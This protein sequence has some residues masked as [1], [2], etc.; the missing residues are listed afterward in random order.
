MSDINSAIATMGGGSRLRK[1]IFFDM[2][3]CIVQENPQLRRVLKDKLED[4]LDDIFIEWPALHS[5][6]N[7][8]INSMFEIEDYICRRTVADFDVFDEIESVT[9]KYTFKTIFMKIHREGTVLSVYEAASKECNNVRGRNMADHVVLISRCKREGHIENETWDVCVNMD[10]GLYKGTVLPDI[11]LRLYTPLTLDN[12]K[13]YGSVIVDSYHSSLEVNG[14]VLIEAESPVVTNNV[15]AFTIAGKGRLTI[16]AK[17]YMQPCIG[18]RTVTGL[19]YGRWSMSNCSPPS[20]IIIDGV[21]V[22]CKSNTE[23]FALGKF[24]SNAVPRIELRNGGHIVCPEMEGTRVIAER[25]E[26]P[27]G[28]TKIFGATRYKIIPIDTT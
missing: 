18:T 22:I 11:G 9:F 3:K 17:G 10:L 19:S 27:A 13:V 4:V 8:L 21:D 26:P 2:T 5:H 6:R 28:S 23:N 1:D 20:K 25:A 24:G 14:D 7:E 15:N 16:V 12:N